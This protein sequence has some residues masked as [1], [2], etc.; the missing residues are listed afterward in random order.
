MFLLIDP[1]MPAGQLH[2]LHTQTRYT[3][4]GR[5][6]VWPS[7][8][9]ISEFL[10]GIGVRRTHGSSAI[11]QCTWSPLVIET[12]G[13]RA[14]P[15]PFLYPLSSRCLRNHRLPAHQAAVPF[16]GAI[17]AAHIIHYSCSQPILASVVLPERI[18]IWALGQIFLC[19]SFTPI[20]TQFFLIVRGIFLLVAAY[21]LFRLGLMHP[22]VRTSSSSTLT[23][24]LSSSVRKPVHHAR[25]EL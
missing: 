23:R 24:F 12:N 11:H 4:G 5:D 20:S 8:R 22:H 14:S 18:G 2:T 17:F 7:R 9:A 21:C 3:R 6:I 25:V 19:A 16:D 1:V 15:A 10:A 13:Q